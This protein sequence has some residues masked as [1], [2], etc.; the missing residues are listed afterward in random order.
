MAQQT[1]PLLYATPHPP[2]PLQS[3]PNRSFVYVF[4]AIPY[5]LAHTWLHPPLLSRIP[6]LLTVSLVTLALFFT[7]LW[8]PHML[9]LSLF[10]GPVLGASYATLMILS[11]SS[12]VVSIIA[13]SFLTEAQIIDVFD[14]VMLERTEKHTNGLTQK[15]QRMIGEKRVLGRIDRGGGEVDWV[16]GEH[17]VYPFLRFK[18]S[19]KASLLFVLELPLNFIPGIGT[20]LFLCLQGYHLGPLHHY[21]YTQLLGYDDAMRNAHIQHNRLQYSL[22]G[23]AHVTLQMIPVLNIFFL[24]ATGAGAALWASKAEIRRWEE[25]QGYLKVSPTSPLGPGYAVPGPGF[26]PGPHSPPGF[27]PPAYNYGTYAPPVPPVGPLP[28]GVGIVVY[29]TVN[30]IEIIHQDI[31]GLAA[32][33]YIHASY[34]LLLPLRWLRYRNGAINARGFSSLSTT[35]SLPGSRAYHQKHQPHAYAPILSPR[36]FILQGMKWDTVVGAS[37][38]LPLPILSLSY[39]AFC[40][41]VQYRVVPLPAFRFVDTSPENLTTIKSGITTINI[42]IIALAL[43]SIRSIITE[44]RGEEFIRLLNLKRDGRS[45]PVTVVDANSLSSPSLGTSKTIPIL[46]AQNCSSWFVVAFIAGLLVTATSSLAPAA[47]SVHEVMLDSYKTTF[48]VAAMPASSVAPTSPDASDT[49]PLHK[50]RRLTHPMRS[51]LQHA[52]SFA[53]AEGALNLDYSP[54]LIRHH[55]GW[56]T[57]VFVMRPSCDWQ[58]SNATMS[59]RQ[60]DDMRLGVNGTLPEL[61][62]GYALSLDPSQ[63]ASILPQATS[64]KGAIPSGSSSNP[65]SRRTAHSGRCSISQK[66]PPFDCVGDLG[67]PVHLDVAILACSPNLAVETVEV[68][69]KGRDITILRPHPSRQGNLDQR[70]ADLFFTALFSPQ[71]PNAATALAHSVTCPGPQ[72]QA[73]L[74]LGWD[75]LG[76]FDEHHGVAREVRFSPMPISDI[77]SVYARYL[78]SA[79][80]PYLAGVL[81]TARV[82]GTVLEPTLVFEAFRPYAIASTILLTILNI[83]SIWASFRSEKGRVSSLFTAGLLHLSSVAEE[84]RRFREDNAK[85]NEE[86]TLKNLKKY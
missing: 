6:P 15:V 78:E 38:L 19:A 66:H 26:A 70:E 61:N 65:S 60:D 29:C 56:V 83:L 39:L 33:S 63:L 41:V 20:P 42:V 77:T 13:E 68:Q 27:A 72:V 48:N 9:I 7:F 43:Q 4:Y 24:F 49:D 57:D 1:T 82:P 74:V 36:L 2:V 40:W 12:T 86:D 47:L 55:S 30:N 54:N 3:L 14:L 25:E 22:F 50:R 59:I 16:L 71:P 8:I 52:A 11:E 44:I 10:H 81:G 73:G 85:L 31:K 69:S 75:V 34:I 23:L 64:P 45:K 46:L 58:S 21:R 67:L 35:H 80:K 5:L 18:D 84:V 62:I 32:L 53:W 51:R 28:H 17:H 76:D 37:K 79:T